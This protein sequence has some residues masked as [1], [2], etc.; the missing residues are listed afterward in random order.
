MAAVPPVANEA[1]ARECV[2]EISPTHAGS[3]DSGGLSV[4][5]LCVRYGDKTVL[6]DVGFV[7]TKGSTTVLLGSSGSGKTTVLRAIAG[8][9]P[10][11]SGA[12]YFDGDRLDTEN[13]EDR[14]VGVVFQDYALFP[15]MTVEQNIGFGLAA[16][17]MPKAER[18]RRVNVMLERLELSNLRRQKPGKLSGGQQQ[19][20]AIG[21]ALVGE[22]RVLLMDEPISA[23][24]RALKAGVLADLRKE[25]RETGVTVV[26][27]THDQTEALALGDSVVVLSDGHVE[28]IGSPSEIYDHPRSAY[29][30]RL[31]GDA[32][33]LPIRGR[34]SACGAGGLMD[35]LRSLR[36]PKAPAQDGAIVIRPE[37]VRVS[38]THSSDGD[39]SPDDS[40]DAITLPGT[41]D[42]VVLRGAELL[43]TITVGGE[44]LTALR[45]RA[46][47]RALARVGD[48]IMITI[49]RDALI[50]VPS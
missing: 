37:N 4:Q 36:G 20:V 44:T 49:L 29:C 34:G 41:I 18:R 8:F 42:D 5:G 33:V 3:T 38:P 30:A 12:I 9:V 11:S 2:T 23:L 26:Y 28:Q 32:N 22:P 21:R 14:N 27:V 16:R 19:R 47:A 24:D 17:G 50:W 1:S 43:Y 10:V 35:I 13:T 45:S 39:P 7:T 25:I 48:A 31:T 46:E 6:T 15:H 40:A